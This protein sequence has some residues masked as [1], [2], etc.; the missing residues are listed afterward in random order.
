MRPVF[1]GVTQYREILS[2]AGE[3]GEDGAI[4]NQ[5]YARAIIGKR[6]AAIGG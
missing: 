3:S 4:G 5:W 1:V 2:A 6:T